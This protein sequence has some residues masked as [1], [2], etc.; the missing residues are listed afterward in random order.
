MPLSFIVDFTSMLLLGPHATMLVAAAGAATRGLIDAHHPQRILGSAAVAMFSIQM[1]G[2]VFG[3]LGGSSGQF[4]WP[5]Q[6]IPIGT[7]G[8]RLGQ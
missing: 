1:A 5:W 4:G 7:A 3:L 8:R 2:V 6:A